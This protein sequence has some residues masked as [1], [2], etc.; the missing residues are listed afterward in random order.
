LKLRRGGATPGH[1]AGVISLPDW[2]CF[3]RRRRHEE[4]PCCVLRFLCLLDLL[5]MMMLIVMHVGLGFVWLLVLFCT[6][7]FTILTL[8]FAVYTTVSFKTSTNNSKKVPIIFLLI[9]LLILD[10]S[11]M[12]VLEKICENFLSCVNSFSFQFC[13]KKPC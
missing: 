7:F 11:C 12:L 6:S 10:G 9:F 2:F 4:E 1:H 3:Q 5:Y 13:K 8:L